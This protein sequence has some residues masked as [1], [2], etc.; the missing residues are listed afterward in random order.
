MK[1]KHTKHSTGKSFCSSSRTVPFA[2][3]SPLPRWCKCFPTLSQ[4]VSFVAWP[5]YQCLDAGAVAKR[6][7][8]QR[9][10]WETEACVSVEATCG[11]VRLLLWVRYQWHN[12]L[13]VV[14]GALGGWEICVCVQVVHVCVRLSLAGSSTMSTMN[15][16]GM[17]FQSRRG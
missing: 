7:S 4:G 16:N 8:G 1:N 5:S 14:R 13:T 12:L 10:S 6:L 15:E 3:S 11:C 9:R 17:M 2:R